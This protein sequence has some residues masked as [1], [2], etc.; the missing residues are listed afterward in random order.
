MIF[1]LEH[2][3]LEEQLLVTTYLVS[4]MLI[5]FSNFN[6]MGPIFVNSQVSFSV[7]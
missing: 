7:V 2:Q 5:K 3:I 4:S 6:K 1:E